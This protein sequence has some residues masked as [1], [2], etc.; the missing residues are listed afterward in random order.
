MFNDECTD[1][2]KDFILSH[3]GRIECI[4]DR[5]VVTP[6][7]RLLSLDKDLYEQEILHEKIF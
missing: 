2:H 5:S 1:R 3:R 6:Y 4:I 7:D